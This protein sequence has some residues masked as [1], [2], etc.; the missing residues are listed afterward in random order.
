MKVQSPLDVNEFPFLFLLFIYSLSL[1]KRISPFS[2]TIITWGIIFSSPIHSKSHLCDQG[3]DD[4]NTKTSKLQKLY[5]DTKGNSRL[6][7]RQQRAAEGYKRLQKATKGHYRQGSRF[8]AALQRPNAS[9]H[10]AK[11]LPDVRSDV[12]L[13]N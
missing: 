5:K 3:W 4:D 7:E 9:C 1:L 13:D 8:W 11:K 10:E 2:Q 12:P 6:Y